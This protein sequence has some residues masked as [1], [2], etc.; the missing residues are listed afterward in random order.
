MTFLIN[1]WG[2]LFVGFLVIIM[3]FFALRS[4]IKGRKSCSGCGGGCTGCSSSS[5]C[6]K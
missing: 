1:N 2:T 6:H 5:T 4:V 3:I